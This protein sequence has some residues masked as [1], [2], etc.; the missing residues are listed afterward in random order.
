[1][2]EV[3]YSVTFCLDEMEMKVAQEK[4]SAFYVHMYSIYAIQ[5]CMKLTLMDKN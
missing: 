4:C 5:I 3:Y 1:M 2:Y